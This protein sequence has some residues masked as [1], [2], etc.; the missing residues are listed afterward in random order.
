MKGKSDK[1][2]EVMFLISGLLDERLSPAENAR[3][4][5][6]L[7]SNAEARRIYMQ[8]VDQE[9]ELSCLLTSAVPASVSS[10]LPVE[11]VGES[12]A[13]NHWRW[14]VLAA[15]AVVLIAVGILALLIPQ[16]WRVDKTPQST[17]APRAFPVVDTWSE[18]FE[19]GQ[20]VGWTGELVT[21]GLPAESRFGIMAVPVRHADGTHHA[22]KLPEDWGKGLVAL[23]RESTLHI[24]YRVGKPGELNVF[25]HTVS[26]EPGRDRY[27]M[28]LLG[29][30]QFPRR[31]GEWLTASIPFS[32]F[33]RKVRIPP[34]DVLEFEGGPPEAGES[35][36]T[37]LFS[38]TEEMDFVIDRIWVTPDGPARE[39]IRPF[40]NSKA[41]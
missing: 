36:T 26:S 1:Y 32:R 9:V 33:V 24:T 15:A 29:A 22:I 14:R 2:E 7:E 5:L 10:I 3:L 12:K 27:G 37:L 17:S 11:T 4:Q 28:Y 16:A 35:I 19:N 31:V 30:P 34:D 39:E 13:T 25:M 18:D 8:M 41:Q 38:S 23:S 20:G 21:V 6:L 40:S